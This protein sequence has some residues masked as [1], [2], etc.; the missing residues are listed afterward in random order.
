MEETFN[1]LLLNQLALLSPL[2]EQQLLNLMDEGFENYHIP[3]KG[4]KIC[5]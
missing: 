2:M 4:N 3:I 5:T 1:D